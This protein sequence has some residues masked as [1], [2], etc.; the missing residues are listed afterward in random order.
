MSGCLLRAAALVD[1]EPL[2]ERQ[3]LV[4]L[5][6]AVC[7]VTAVFEL[8]RRRKLREE[9]S[10]VWVA[11]ALALAVLAVNHDLLITLSRWIGAASSVSTLFFGALLFLLALVL[12]FSVRLTRLTHRNRT[13]GQRLALLEEE[14]QRLRRERKAAPPEPS[15]RKKAGASQD[16]VA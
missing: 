13:L 11:T 10:M 4:A 8:V 15:L 6:F 16:E 7:M 5:I 1:L 3:R 12:Q 9:Y 14:V 2:P